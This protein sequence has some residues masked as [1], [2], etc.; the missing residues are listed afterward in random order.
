MDPMTGSNPTNNPRLNLLSGTGGSAGGAYGAGS[1]SAPTGGAPQSATSY[2]A[3]AQSGAPAPAPAPAPSPSNSP[4]PS[5]TPMY[6][7]GSSG[8]GETGSNKAVIA[9][10]AVV[11]LL[12]LGGVGAFLALN[13]G[14][15]NNQQATDTSQQDQNQDGQ[16]LATN[17]IKN[18]DTIETKLLKVTGTEEGVDA[19]VVD[20]SSYF[21][22]PVKTGGDLTVG[23]NLT[24]TGT[25]TF[26]GAVTATE[27]IGD[28]SK[29]TGIQTG[30]GAAGPAGA[31]GATGARG[32][33]GAPNPNAINAQNAD[34]LDGYDSSAF[35]RLQ[36]SGSTPQNGNVIVTGNFSSV[37]TLGPIALT[38]APATVTP[39]SGENVLDSNTNH[40]F[41]VVALSGSTVIATSPT[42]VCATGPSQNAC[43]LSW[44][45]QLGATGYVIYRADPNTA[46]FTA[47][48][49]LGLATSYTYRNTDGET[50]S[51]PVPGTQQ[52]LTTAVFGG[53]ATNNYTLANFGV[54]TT[55]PTARLDVNGDARISGALTV[56]DLTIN[57]DL[58]V[59]G[60]IS[61]SGNM[62]IAGSI[63]AGG[64]ISGSSLSAGTG[65][66]SGGS[67]SVGS[68]SISGGAISGTSLSVSG[69]LA[70]G[71]FGTFGD[72]LA[73]GLISGNTYRFFV[74]GS[75]GDV[76]T[77]GSL[78]SDVGVYTPGYGAFGGSLASSL[79][80]GNTY[81]FFV[82]ATTGS[83]STTGN[84]TAGG[85]IVTQNGSIAGENLFSDNGITA[86]GDIVSQ[87]DILSGG[88]ISSNGYVQS[89]SSFRHNGN[90]GVNRDCGTGGTVLKNVVVSGGIITAGVCGPDDIGASDYAERFPSNQTIAAGEV[91][92]L[93]GGSER[94]VRSTAVGQTSAIGVV[95]TAP[96]QVIGTGNTI[97]ALAGRVP[98]KIVG[99][100][101]PGDYLTSSGTP[102]HAQKAAPGQR[103]IGVAMTGGS[104]GTVIVFVNPT[105]TPT[106]V[107]QEA[108]QQ[109]E[110][111]EASVTQGA[112]D[113]N[114]ANL[115]ASGLTTLNDLKV[116][117]SAT[118]ATLTVTGLAKVNN[119]EIDGHI[120]GNADTRG[121]VTIPAG[122]KSVT[123]TFAK[124]YAAKPVVVA[125][126]VGVSAAVSVTSTLN[127]FT[128]TV[129]EAVAAPLE[130]NY[131]VQE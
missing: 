96:A 116:T 126:P 88:N 39:N 45:A 77:T 1:V 25:G 104:G 4:R 124:P 14:G 75:T 51:S 107:Q 41:K 2:I 123:K 84:V 60:D 122:Q 28:G 46:N 65:S 131:V 11:V 64:S 59:N 81:R 5:Y 58:S 111:A 102:G 8:G 80:S 40:A 49:N 115:N 63:A 100:V 37:T 72:D 44:P 105:T 26:G 114:F 113:G 106:A 12:L 32:P 47:Y 128:I 119:I 61:G 22:G 86:Q 17:N 33:A 121:T 29:L 83:V 42:T 91:V 79:I 6:T 110:T 67:L 3:A 125:T 97:V 90:I 16:D 78:N 56:S 35:V 27:F 69:G 95:S 43:S 76:T 103:A 30:G 7:G 23:G 85:D 93:E 89:V 38:A 98:V 118:I 92:A 48:R 62:T 71:T 9:I 127:G 13:S 117:G 108:E 55:N 130:L 87:N 73:V 18:A 10:V 120:K 53:S 129:D 112:S 24:V 101:A 34:K 57:D 52:A 54:G 109:V 68:G 66:I 31:R 82:N 21:Q 99:D 15:N 19:L 70:A 74:E 94:V 50:T 20:G 36:A